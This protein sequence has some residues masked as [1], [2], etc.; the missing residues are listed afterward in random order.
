M[1]IRLTRAVKALLIACFAGFLLQQT[2]DQFFGGDLL[3]WL[4]LT[5]ADVILR[6]RWWQLVTYA[7]LH[8]DVMHLVFNLLMLVFLGSELEARWGAAFFLRY[9][10]FCLV[11]AGVVYLLVQPLVLGADGLRTPMVGASGGIYGLLTAYGILFAERT[12]L[13]M[14]LFPMKAKHF[15]WVLAGIEFLSSLYSG[16]NGLSSVAHLSGMGAGFGFLWVR[17]RL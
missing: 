3:G 7:F 17:A 6:H 4:G 14:L 9:Y 12:L 15:V 10:F 8:A 2:I 1:P 11:S 16:R 13:L 5:P